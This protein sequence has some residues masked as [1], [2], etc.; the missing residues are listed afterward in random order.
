M[1][2]LDLTLHDEKN[3]FRMVSLAIE[4]IFRIKLHRFE[5]WEEGP[6]KVRVLVRQKAKFIYDFY[7]TLA[8][9]L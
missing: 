1:A 6:K 2:K 5:D 7:V 9:D 3:F 4:D 8:H